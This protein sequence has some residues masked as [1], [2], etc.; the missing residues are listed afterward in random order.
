MAAFED[1][2]NPATAMPDFKEYQVSKDA[3]TNEGLT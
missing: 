1:Q 3:V 2:G